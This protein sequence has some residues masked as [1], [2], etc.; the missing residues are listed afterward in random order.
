MVKTYNKKKMSIKRRL[1]WINM[2]E[3]VL[4]LGIIGVVGIVSIFICKNTFLQF[5]TSRSVIDEN[6]DEVK[7][8]IEM[9]YGNQDFT[10][11]N[12]LIESIAS[13][14]YHIEIRKNNEMKYDNFN[15][16]DR[17][18]FEDLKLNEKEITGKVRS[19]QLEGRTIV[20]IKG[21]MQDSVVQV[22]AIKENINAENKKIL[23][24]IDIFPVFISIILIIMLLIV[25]V[26]YFCSRYM[27]R[28]LLEP[29]NLLEEAALRIKNNNLDERIYYEGD[30]EFETVFNTFN[31]MQTQLKKGVQKNIA[32]EKSRTEMIA[33]ISHDLKTPLTAVKGYLKGI[34]DGIAD[35]PEKQ[36]KYVEIA[37]ARSCEMEILLEKLFLFSKLETKNMPFYFKTINMDT[38]ILNYLDLRKSE[39]EGKGARFEL[40]LNSKGYLVNLDIEQMNRVLLNIISNSIKYKRGDIVNINIITYVK[41]NEVILIIKDDGVGVS[42]EK[43]KYLFDSFYR[44][45]ESRNNPKEGN[46]LG[47]AI[48]KRII[49]SHN[50]S[51]VASSNKG[52]EITIKIPIVKKEG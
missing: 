25:L 49:E 45:D 43:L 15:E 12:L 37:Y 27:I 34:I 16:S 8:S 51:I 4:S 42:E 39:F 5:M 23:F 24:I 26:N 3:V 52:L 10:S 50:G 31:E 29:I 14:G 7:Q 18:L 40:L 19:Y 35:T 1:M 22:S 11:I 44:A 2:S 9:F 48:V 21:V 33:G 36:K 46:G 20:S 47:L 30:L 41:Y 6:V 17:E 32:Y 13:R 38:Y 28:Y